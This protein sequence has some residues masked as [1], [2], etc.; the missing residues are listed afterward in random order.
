MSATAFDM[1]RRLCGLSLQE[2]ADL[3]AV[4]LDTVK[5]WSAG[6]R[7]AG[8]AILGELRT[9]WRAIEASAEILGRDID[10]AVAEGGGD[11]ARLE[12]SLAP[13]AAAAR[14]RG[15]PCPGAHGAAI[16]LAI[17]GRDLPVDV[18]IVERGGPREPVCFYV[19]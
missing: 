16:A 19:P 1:L 8:P 6:R 9:L 11:G 18:T 14:L 12:L 13:D 15:L 4:R 5:S 2:A 10:R 17:A 3:L 7:L